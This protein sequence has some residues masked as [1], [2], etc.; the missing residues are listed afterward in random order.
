MG[1]EKENN[2]QLELFSQ[3]DERQGFKAN[4]TNPAFERIWNYEKAILAIIALLATG[5]IAFSMGVENGKSSILN[6]LAKAQELAKPQNKPV[7][8]Q[9]M[10]RKDQL[11]RQAP[12]A[13]SRPGAFTIQVATFKTKINAQKEA[14][15]IKKMGLS[16][17]LFNKDGYFILC[18]GDFPNKEAALAAA[19][20]LNKRYEACQIRRL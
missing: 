7:P 17:I 5:I 19:A 8:A 2:S 12:L 1:M 14:E 13:S 20:E 10:V 6:Q 4:T 9:V 3:D 16:A 18:A 15:V 11:V